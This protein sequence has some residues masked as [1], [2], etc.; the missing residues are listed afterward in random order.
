MAPQPENYHLT[1]GGTSVVAH[2]PVLGSP[3][4][5][6]WGPSLGEISEGQLE[7]FAAAQVP[8][9]YGSTSDTA[10]ALSL[11]PQQSEG[12]SGTPGLVG[13]R[14][15]IALFPLFETLSATADDFDN[16]SR[17][18]TFDSVDAESNVRL[19]TMLELTPSGL[20]RTRAELTNIGEDG[21]ALDSLLLALPT[22]SAET[23]VI[24]QTGHHLRERDIQTHDFTIGTHAQA[25]HMNRGHAASS[26][27]GTCANGAGWRSGP[28]HYI[29]V[30]WSGN[31]RS[32]AE[33]DTLGFQTLMGGQLLLPG[34]VG[35]NA[36][37]TYTS[38]WIY[39]TWGEGLDE[40]AGRIHDYLRARPNHPAAPRPVT[41]NAW[42][43]IYFDH[44]LPRLLELADAAA[45]IGAERFVLDDGW[46]GSRRDDT[47]G[48]G[49][50]VIS[51]DV[52]PDGLTPLADAVHKNGMQFGLWFEPEM[53]NPDSDAARAHP[54]WILKPATHMPIE[55]RQQ[56]VIDLTNPEA[57]EHVR[58]QMLAVLDQTPIDYIKWD[59]NRDMHEAVSQRS[60]RPVYNDQ[61]KATYALME[62]LLE[63]HPELEIES[64]AGGGGRIDLEM[65][66]RAV[67]I[68][69]SDCIDPLERV[70]IEAGTALLLPPE[71][72]GSH[73]A[74]QVS[75]TTGRN[76]NL[77]LRAATAMFSHMGI[78][79][80]L[81]QASDDDRAELAAWVTF[82][83]KI[84]PLLH[85]GRE[86]HA[87]HPDDGYWVHGV[88]APDR[89]EAVYSI[90]RV[91]TSAQ[92][93]TPPLCL[94]G[95][96]AT[97]S[98]TVSEL[99][100]EGVESTIA[101]YG[102]TQVPWWGG[103][104]YLTGSALGLG[105][106]RFPDLNPE[107]VILLRIVATPG[108]GPQSKELSS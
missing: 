53:I 67:R 73:V 16:G 94:P 52:W 27:H 8:Y 108:E 89:S 102:G 19:V 3:R 106:I 62:A 83:K 51:E 46:F 100:P 76:L 65:M 60:G 101:G 58:G 54:E 105:G 72:V 91:A 26:I 6:Y 84:R 22:P 12:W 82:H 75:H 2:V 66:N 77:T 39:A 68:W 10:P 50:W 78:E 99:L 69:A 34:E 37:Q 71:L 61:V 23:Q 4:V 9:T 49:D 74:S 5:L 35:L 30:A 7:S 1:C 36:G 11:C 55:A 93:P 20:L 85:T 24:D 32:L 81:T 29:H 43:A 15:G 21:Y 57:F 40:A 96:D 63:A 70:L 45:Q 56:Q 42:E 95:L 31:T 28:V 13:S 17:A 88:V 64:C 104:L 59:F 98:Y 107:Q 97:A 79:W 86:V 103:E 47:A 18:I 80:D 14:G 44:S 25:L 33:K 38:P 90:T 92:R 41:F 48:L 87:D